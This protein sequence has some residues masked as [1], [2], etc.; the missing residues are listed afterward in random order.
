MQP[1]R[2]VPGPLTWFLRKAAASPLEHLLVCLNHSLRRPVQVCHA[3]DT[4]SL[5]TWFLFGKLIGV[6]TLIVFGEKRCRKMPSVVCFM[7]VQNLPPPSRFMFWC[8]APFLVATI[9]LVPP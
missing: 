5:A 7:R 3:A 4:A 9:V 8:T 1:K 6:A 2:R